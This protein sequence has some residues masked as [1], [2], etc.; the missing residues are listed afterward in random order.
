MAQQVKM[1]AP[2]SND[3]SLLP[4]SH[5]VEGDWALQIVSDL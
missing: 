1:L 4:E 3:L 5:V 2:K